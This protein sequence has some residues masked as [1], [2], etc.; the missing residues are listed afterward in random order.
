VRELQHH[1]LKIKG[2]Q[3]IETELNQKEA[4]I[5][6][7][8]DGF[9]ADPSKWNKETALYFS[10]LESIELTSTHWEVIN[11][12]RNYYYKFGSAPMVRAISKA[13]KL[14]TRQL[15]ELFPAGPLKQAARIGGLPK[16]AGCQ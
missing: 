2:S 14:S 8:K 6:L 15:Y 11:Y 9:L 4:Q 5:G 12:F 3:R 10:N 16:P 1:G 13:T 7:D